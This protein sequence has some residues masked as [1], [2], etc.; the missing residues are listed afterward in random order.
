MAHI[1][2]ELHEIP[3]PYESY[4]N[5]SDGRVFIMNDD[6]FGNRK[7]K[8]IGRA[9]SETMMHPNELYKYLYPSLW[10]E[11][12]GEMELPEHELH[13]GLYALALGIGYKTNLYPILHEVYGP[14]YGNAIMD[15]AMYSILER[16]DTSQLFPDR[17]AQQVLFSKEVY[18]DSWFSDLFRKQMTGNAN[19]QFKIRWIKDSVSSGVTKVWL[20]I[21]GSNND[22][23]VSRSDLSEHGNTKS[24]TNSRIV[25]YIGAVSAK[26]G[27]PVTYFVNNGGMADCKAFQ[28]IAAFLKSTGIEIE[29]VII[30]RG[31]CTHDVLQTIKEC[32]CPYIVMLKSDNYG[33]TQM[34]A[35]FADTIRW[36]VPYV[37]N[38]KGMFGIA[39]RKQIFGQYPEEAYITCF[40]TESMVRQDPLP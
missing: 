33:H 29:G 34:M 13:A 27:R 6:G 18:S 22:C 35:E 21:D 31:F 14:L 11:Y 3:R 38:N 20:S 8:V 12:Y 28:E 19:Y 25:S 32:G 16:T 30:D 4:I 1:F 26:D 23:T 24:H 36:K 39:D 2:W 40:L 5:H 17:M 37:V 15:Y 9:T 10:K 7:R